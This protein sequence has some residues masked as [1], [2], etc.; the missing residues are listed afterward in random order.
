MIEA[1]AAPTTIP[2][3]ATPGRRPFLRG[4]LRRAWR[5]TIG[6]LAIIGLVTVLRPFLFDLTPLVSGSMSPT[7]MG[8]KFS[9]DW[10]LAEKVSYYF[11]KPRRGEVIEF[12][13]DDG[14][15][16]MKRV[17]A[18]PGE[19]IAVE[20]NRVKVNGTDIE[21]P[22]GAAHVKYYGYGNLNR[23][24]S[25]PYGYYVLGDDSADSEDSRY[26]GPVREEQVRGRAWLIVWPLGRFGWVR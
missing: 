6:F 8:D 15:K 22:P 17:M 1:A 24:Y 13:G 9:G 5:F 4:M 23:P 20:K 19:T 26:E 14:L 12:R 18:F 2:R 10:V 7:L 25:V 21:P 11:R 3:A 16:I